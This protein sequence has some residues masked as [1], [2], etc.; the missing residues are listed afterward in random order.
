MQRNNMD[1]FMPCCFPQ[2]QYGEWG[3]SVVQGREDDDDNNK[4]D[5]EL[6]KLGAYW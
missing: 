2:L 1:S 3:F 4:D 5:R 6:D